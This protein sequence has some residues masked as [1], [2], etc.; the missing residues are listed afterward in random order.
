MIPITFFK[1]ETK[2]NP[3]AKAQETMV[4]FRLPYQGSNGAINKTS[5]KFPIISSKPDDADKI[6]ESTKPRLVSENLA[7]RTAAQETLMTILKESL[8]MLHPFMPFVTEEI[9]SILP[10]KDRK[11]LMIESW[12]IPDNKHNLMSGTVQK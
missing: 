1:I 10:I 12:P 5:Q 7:D 3:A 9:Y 2:M 4:Q 6:I 11:L 8:K